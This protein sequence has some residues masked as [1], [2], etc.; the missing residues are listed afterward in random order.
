MN[1]EQTHNVLNLIRNGRHTHWKHQETQRNGYQMGKNVHLQTGEG[2]EQGER[3]WADGRRVNWW[4]HLGTLC[5]SDSTGEHSLHL[6]GDG[7]G[8]SRPHHLRGRWRRNRPAVP[9]IGQLTG[10]V[11]QDV[12]NVFM[13]PESSENTQ[14]TANARPSRA[15]ETP[16]SAQG[17]SWR[18]TCLTTFHPIKFRPSK[19]KHCAHVWDK[20]CRKGNRHPRIRRSHYVWWG[21]LSRAMMY[22]A[23]IRCDRNAAFLLQRVG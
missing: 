19:S 8:C 20:V 4:S 1:G 13:Q 12:L 3:L 16:G 18:R 21:G 7:Q 15:S 9:W 17:A 23:S 14:T 5:P 22:A 10:K 11:S 6:P 2:L